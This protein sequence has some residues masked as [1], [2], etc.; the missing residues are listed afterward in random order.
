MSGFQLASG[1]GSSTATVLGFRIYGADA[2]RAIRWL[3]GPLMDLRGV[4]RAIQYRIS[5]RHQYH[6]VNTGLR[7]GYYDEDTR[8]LHACMSLLV[9]HVERGHGGAGVLQEFTDQLRNEPDLWGGAPV[10]SQAD[11]QAEVIAIYHWWKVQRPA[12][13]ER[14]DAMSLS[15]YGEHPAPICTAEELWAFEDK[16]HENDQAMLRRLIEVRRGLWT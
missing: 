2:P 13:W 12:D 14:E 10:D 16:L 15:L 1:L 3:Y 8:M 5:P 4:K 7:P 11:H 9:E 6:L